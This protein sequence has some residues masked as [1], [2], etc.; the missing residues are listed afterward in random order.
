MTISTFIGSKP[1]KYTMPCRT[2]MS[3]AY[4]NRWSRVY[5]SLSWTTPTNSPLDSWT[6]SSVVSGGSR[7]RP[8]GVSKKSNF[9]FFVSTRSDTCTWTVASRLVSCVIDRYI[10]G[11]PVEVSGL[12]NR[13]PV[14]VLSGRVFPPKYKT[15]L[16][17]DYAQGCCGFGVIWNFTH[18]HQDLRQQPQTS[19]H[20]FGAPNLKRAWNAHMKCVVHPHCIGSS[21]TITWVGVSWHN[22][23]T[24]DE[25]VVCGFYLQPVFCPWVCQFR[26][27]H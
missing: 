20:H 1:D 3:C 14:Q 2:P 11:P 17:R 9:H 26:R 6:N 19:G 16:F 15:G 18:D 12:D 24:W 7:W 27:S 8:D 25:T 22:V 10:L 4:R 23:H 13:H 21:T 5:L